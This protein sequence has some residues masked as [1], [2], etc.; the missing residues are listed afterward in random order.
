MMR[1]SSG[2]PLTVSSGVDRSR[3]AHGYDRPNAVPGVDPNLADDRAQPQRLVQ[4]GGVSNERARHVWRPRAQHPHR[5]GRVRDRLLGAQELSLRRQVFSAAIEAFNLLNRPNFGD[6]DTNLA[7][8]NWNVAGANGIPTA[9]S[10]AF[11]TI[12]ST[13]G[14]DADASVAVCVEIRLLRPRF[15]QVRADLRGTR[16]GARGE[17]RRR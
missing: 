6:P 2:F 7:Q 14:N 13:R 11:G 15:T 16:R 8:S 5:P 12:N 1:M 9:G 4:R 3:T 17:S 10:G